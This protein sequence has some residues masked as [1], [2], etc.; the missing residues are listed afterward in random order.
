MFWVQEKERQCVVTDVRW[1]IMQYL[2]AL[3]QEHS[4]F[5]F[6]FEWG[7]EEKAD[8]TLSRGRRPSLTLC[9]C[10]LSHTSHGT[11]CMLVLSHLAFSVPFL[12]TI[13]FSWG[14]CNRVR[15]SSVPPRLV[16]QSSCWFSML[17]LLL[18]HGGTLKSFRNNFLKR[19]LLWHKLIWKK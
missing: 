12:L 5:S 3:G 17:F 13:M 4:C 15:G 10:S 11:H 16:L 14:W 19:Y 18:P 8:S 7:A 9:I 2:G 6:I 1:L